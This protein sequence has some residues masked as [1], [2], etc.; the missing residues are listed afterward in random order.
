MLGRNEERHWKLELLVLLLP[1][2]LVLS[3]DLVSFIESCFPPTKST[4]FV[5]FAKKS[6]ALLS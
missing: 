1:E 2:L 5:A 4:T 3:Q 6:H